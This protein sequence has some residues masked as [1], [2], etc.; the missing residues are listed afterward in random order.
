MLSLDRQASPFPGVVCPSGGSGISEEGRQSM[1]ET[2][3]AWALKTYGDS[4]KTKTV[5]R[6]K[7]DRIMRILTGEEEASTENSKFRFW[8]KAKG[9]KL[10][11]GT[12]AG[13]VQNVLYVPVKHPVSV[14]QP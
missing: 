3:Q 5:T 9:F 1:Y 11:P 4:G 7:Y 2:F 10:G 6:R 12:V 8:V 14:S 13:R